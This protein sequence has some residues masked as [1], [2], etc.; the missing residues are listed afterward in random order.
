MYITEINTLE[1]AVVLA[2]LL[3]PLAAEP[4]LLEDMLRVKMVIR[5]TKYFD[6]LCRSGIFK[7]LGRIRVCC[8][9]LTACSCVQLT[10]GVRLWHFPSTPP[11]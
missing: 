5:S 8:A 2:I 10:H 9:V 4:F 1:L 3:D 6:K 11:H 7:V